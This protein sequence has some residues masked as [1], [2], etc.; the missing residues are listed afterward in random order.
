MIHIVLASGVKEKGGKT[1]AWENPVNRNRDEIARG[2]AL[3]GWPVHL[4]CA[5]SKN[6]FLI[7]RS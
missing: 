2:S 4:H 7:D 5:H 3:T 1:I 6:R